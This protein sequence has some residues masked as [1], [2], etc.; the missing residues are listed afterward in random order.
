MHHALSNPNFKLPQQFQT[1]LQR[2]QAA[3]CLP[4]ILSRSSFPQKTIPRAIFSLTAATG[5]GGD[6]EP[7]SAR[8]ELWQGIEG[9]GEWLSGRWSAS[10]SSSTYRMPPSR[11]GGGLCWLASLPSE[12]GR[13]RGERE[14]ESTRKKTGPWY[15]TQL[16]WGEAF[17]Q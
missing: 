1:P 3:S 5:G 8:T 17:Q 11:G 13:E 10:R 12:G 14:R 2:S 16:W 4:T 15:L 7:V 6:A 9:G